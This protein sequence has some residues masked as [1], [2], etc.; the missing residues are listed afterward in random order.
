M[1][2]P[3]DQ[4][5]PQNGNEHHSAEE[6]RKELDRQSVVMVSMLR[7]VLKKREDIAELK[8][9]LEAVRASQADL[10]RQLEEISIRWCDTSRKED[11]EAGERPWQSCV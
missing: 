4:H 10:Q 1:K 8:A 9:K 3:M 11:R 2:I 5:P 6:L 7:G